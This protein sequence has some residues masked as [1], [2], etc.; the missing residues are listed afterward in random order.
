[1]YKSSKGKRQRVNYQSSGKEN[2]E[3]IPPIED[4]F[5]PSINQSEPM[6]ELFKWLD[7]ETTKSISHGLAFNDLDEIDL[8][9]FP[10]V[11]TEIDFF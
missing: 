10:P 3:E 4:V 9:L 2:D 6:D 5:F 7:E 1:M 8:G 11:I